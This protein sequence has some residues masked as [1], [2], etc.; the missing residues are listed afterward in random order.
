[1]RPP[2]AIIVEGAPAKKRR[3]PSPA[4][5]VHDRQQDSGAGGAIA[6]CLALML[7]L[8]LVLAVMQ[9]SR[10][11]YG[12]L[13]GEARAQLHLSLAAVGGQSIVVP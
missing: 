9:G 13:E 3:A 6:D 8:V 2:A 7:R 10:A 4:C 11:R 1:M 5:R 12:R